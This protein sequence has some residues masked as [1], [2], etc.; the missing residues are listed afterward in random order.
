[1]N[2]IINAKIE[3]KKLEFGPK[4]CFNIHIGKKKEECVNQ[5]VHEHS[6]NETSYETYLG[7]IACSSGTNDRNI[8]KRHNQGIGSVAQIFT[9]LKSSQLRPLSF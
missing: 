7:D 5:K 6:I 2:A 9:M 1:M 8:E 4:K 3:S